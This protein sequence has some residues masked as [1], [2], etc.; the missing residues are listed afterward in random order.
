MRYFAC[1]CAAGFVT[2]CTVLIAAPQVVPRHTRRP[3][4]A[5]WYPRQWLP[6]FGAE[7]VQMPEGLEGHFNYLPRATRRMARDLFHMMVAYRAGL[8]RKQQLLGRLVDMGGEIFAMAA[9]LSM[10]AARGGKEDQ[11]LADLFCRQARRRIKNLRRA[12]Y[13]N[14]DDKAYRV[15]RNLLDGGYPYLEENIL[16]TWRDSA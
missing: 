14:D 7:D 16:S 11:E 12:V 1:R 6:V 8:Q 3:A 15:A 9:T 2:I 5:G 4:Y 10:A 13:S